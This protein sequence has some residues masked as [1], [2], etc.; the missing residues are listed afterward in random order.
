[1]KRFAFFDV[2]ET[3]IYEKS[4]FSILD[5]I[6]K[7]FPSVQPGMIQKCL[8]EL[9]NKGV[10]RSIINRAFYK[11]LKGLPRRSII[12][13]SNNYIDKRIRDN[14]KFL[15]SKVISMM[16]LYRE[17]GYSPVFISGSAID[18]I[19]PLAKYLH[20]TYCLATKLVIDK[21]G[22]YTGEIE[23]K[24][25]I[26]EGKRHSI[27]DFLR[28]HAVEASFCAGFG[29][30]TSDLSFLEL[31]GEPHVVATSDEKLVFIAQQ[32]GWPVIYP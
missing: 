17:K 16:D 31:I 26:G 9:R 30:H 1:M 32:R 14:N 15:I 29:D 24:S 5:E 21:D 23:G 4:M 3:I 18:F 28:Q 12:D 13:I 27:Q 7:I 11:E 2:D 20:V 25:M 10:E 8:Q 6:S 22:I 19:L